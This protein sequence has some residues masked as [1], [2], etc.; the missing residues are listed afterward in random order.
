MPQRRLHEAPCSRYEVVVL[1]SLRL[2]NFRGFREFRM[3]GLGRVNLL[4]GTNNCGKTSVLEAIQILAAP[5]APWPLWET[6]VRR[7]ETREGGDERE[8]EVAH[9]VHGHQM[10]A[11]ASFSVAGTNDGDERNVKATFRERMA[12]LTRKTTR[13]VELFET[14]SDDERE[15]APLELLIEWQSGEQHRSLEWPLTRRGGLLRDLLSTEVRRATAE[16]SPVHFITTEGLT[17]DKVVALFDETVLTPDE[18]TVLQALRTIDPSIE[19]V[20]SV[21]T[22]RRYVF[23]ARGGIVMLA[24]GKR[25]PIGSMGDGIWRLLGIALALVRARGG[26]LLVDEIDTGLHYTVLVDMWRLVLDTARR[27][28]VQV[29]AT[30]H[31][32][33][34]YEALAATATEGGYDISL[35][36]IERG[37]DLAVAFTES[38]IRQAADRGIEVR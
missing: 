29:F 26:T 14:D 5:G 7:G 38:E 12:R 6:L 36:R 2:R 4:V 3:A 17:R 10:D 35:Q 16:L 15:L 37:R 21:G 28:E 1:R 33:D 24:E 27:L 18:S 13:Q 19:R 34:C 20:A 9:I 25:L 23:G 32:R 8:V 11:E 30:T 31:S 22:S